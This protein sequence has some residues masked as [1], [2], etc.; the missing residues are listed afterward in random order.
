MPQLALSSP[1]QARCSERSER[2]TIDHSPNPDT[3]PLKLSDR[4]RGTSF[5]L[6]A[7]ALSTAPAFGAPEGVATAWG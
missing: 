2:R 3:T 1:V 7:G 6:A 4:N 5:W